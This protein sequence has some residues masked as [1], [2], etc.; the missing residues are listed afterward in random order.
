MIN[1][2]GS[3]H[4]RPSRSLLALEE[5][6]VPYR[7]VPL[8]PW[9]EDADRELVARL[10]PNARVPILEEDG[11][12]LWESMAINIYLAERAGGPIWPKNSLDRGRVYQW[13]LWAQTEVDILARHGARNGPDGPAKAAAQ[14]ARLAALEVLERALGDRSYLLGPD[15]TLADLNVAST[16]SEPW[17]NGLIDGDLDPAAQG[18]P[19][20]AEW[21]GR[22]LQRPSW[23]RVRALP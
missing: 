8:R 1:L 18:L 11:F 9:A 19:A 23:T 13:S 15:F 10:N 4:G 3:A 12:I 20:V 6:G 14:S 21:L 7:H 5:L 16:L 22:C 17:E 2:Y